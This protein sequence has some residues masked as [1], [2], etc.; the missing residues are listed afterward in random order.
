MRFVPYRLWDDPPIVAF[1]ERK[2]LPLYALL[3][4][5]EPG[6]HLLFHC[7]GQTHACAQFFRRLAAFMRRYPRITLHLMANTDAEARAF[8]GLGV[9]VGYGPVSL[10]IDETVFRPEPVQKVFDAVYIARFTPGD[11]GHFKRH[12]LA[13]RIRSLSIIT[14]ALSRASESL[15]DGGFVKAFRETYPELRHAAVNDRFVPAEDVA[16]RLNLARVNLGLSP[17]EGCMLGFTEGLLC[18]LPGVSTECRSA[19]TEFFDPRYVSVVAD[20]AN[21]V[22]QGVREL[23]ARDLD[24]ALVRKSALTRQQQMRRRYAEH[25]AHIAETGVDDVYRH[26]FEQPGGIQRLEQAQGT[27]KRIRVMENPRVS[28]GPRVR[29]SWVAR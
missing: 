2:R 14:N 22:A 23:I 6:T 26:L 13:A 11:R 9:S 16:H 10:Y 25:I 12:L 8:A 7:S 28:R 4:E 18:G 21:A 20:D 5:L 29:R 19:R 1:Q 3:R 17:A 24:P 15:P 27:A